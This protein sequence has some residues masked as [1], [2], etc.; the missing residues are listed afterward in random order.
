MAISRL[1]WL[2]FAAV[3]AVRLFLRLFWWLFELLWGNV[4]V[5]LLGPAF[6]G[7]C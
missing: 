1:G 3:L 6:V 7:D 2:L 4:A 5:L